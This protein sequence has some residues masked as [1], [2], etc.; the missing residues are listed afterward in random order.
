MIVGS[1]LFQDHLLPSCLEIYRRTNN[2]T[3]ENAFLVA[4]SLQNC[5]DYIVTLFIGT[6]YLINEKI[7]NKWPH[8]TFFRLLAHYTCV[9]KIR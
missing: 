2:Y 5:V 4:S 6:K 7:P 1:S 8:F 3:R 9:I